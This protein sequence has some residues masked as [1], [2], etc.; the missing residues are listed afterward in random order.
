VGEWYDVLDG[1]AMFVGVF[2]GEDDTPAYRFEFQGGRQFLTGFRYCLKADDPTKPPTREALR[3]YYKPYK[4]YHMLGEP[5]QFI[6]WM[7]TGEMLF[8]TPEGGWSILTTDEKHSECNDPSATKKPVVDW[9][10]M[11]AWAVAVAMDQGGVWYCYPLGLPVLGQ[12]CWRA[13]RGGVAIA[14]PP[15]HAPKFNGDWKDSLVIRPGVES[16]K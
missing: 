3:K 13:L 12:A 9:A 8:N 11:P 1:P 15:S 4:W 14:I 5:L 16:E 2:N 10:A 7:Q 6:G